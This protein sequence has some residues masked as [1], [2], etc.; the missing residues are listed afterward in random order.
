MMEYGLIGSCEEEELNY[1]DSDIRR[2]MYLENCKYNC[3]SP[4]VMM[5]RLGVEEEA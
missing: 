3:K 4:M 1:D 5:G 2:R